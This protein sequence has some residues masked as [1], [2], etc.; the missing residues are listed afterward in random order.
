[1]RHGATESNEYEV[2]CTIAIGL[3]PFLTGMKHTATIG[4]DESA[5]H[6]SPETLLAIFLPVKGCECEPISIA[7][8]LGCHNE[9]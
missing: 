5:L 2:T 7:V 8:L 4:W 6:L 3:D 9:E 1:L